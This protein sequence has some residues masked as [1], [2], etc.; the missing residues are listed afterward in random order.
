MCIRFQLEV[1]GLHTYRGPHTVTIALQMQM[2]TGL[3]HLEGT[4]GGHGLKGGHRVCI[5][6]QIYAAIRIFLCALCATYLR[7]IEQC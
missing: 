7:A 4:T 1:C 3:L 6:V 5:H 2:D